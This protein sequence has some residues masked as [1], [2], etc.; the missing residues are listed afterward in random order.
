MS[1]KVEISEIEVVDTYH[2]LTLGSSYVYDP[3]KI[4]KCLT[5]IFAHFGL[6]I[7]KFDSAAYNTIQMRYNRIVKKIK[8]NQSATRRDRHFGFIP[9]KLFYSESDFP[10]LCTKET[11]TR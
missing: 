8:S 9:D 7:A 10:D 4:S 2:L 3:K 5:D 11:S 1:N 6:K